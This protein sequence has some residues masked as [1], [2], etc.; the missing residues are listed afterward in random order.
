M[1]KIYKKIPEMHY[2]SGKCKWDNPRWSVS[3]ETILAALD[4][5]NVQY[6]MISL[7]Y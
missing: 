1:G 7:Q 6:I 4:K 5:E 3:C 2:L